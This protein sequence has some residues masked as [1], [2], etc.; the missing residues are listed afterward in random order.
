MHVE[1][2][3]EDKDAEEEHQRRRD[4]LDHAHHGER[5]TLRGVGKPEQWNNRDDPCPDQQQVGQPV[6][7][8]YYAAARGLLVEQKCYCRQENGPRF[9]RHTLERRQPR[10]LLNHAID[11]KGKGQGEADPRQLAI[12]EGDIQHTGRCQPHGSP[13]SPVQTLAKD[14]HADHDVDKRRD[15]VAQAGVDQVASVD[16]PDIDVPVHRQKEGGNHVGDQGAPRMQRR[17][18]PRPMTLYC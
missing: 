13:L 14:Q 10:L 2:L 6:S 8:S 1:R 11:A 15:K 12:A 9:K 7:V 3:V 4:V 16:S 17:A 18:Q 5:D